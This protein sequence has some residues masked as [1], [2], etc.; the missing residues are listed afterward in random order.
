MVKKKKNINQTVTTMLIDGENV[1]CAVDEEP[2]FEELRMK[3][4][5]IN[6]IEGITGYILR[7]TSDAVI[8]LKDQAML[9]DYAILSSQA[10]DFGQEI[11]ELF[12]LG[13]VENIVV[14]GKDVKVVCVNINENKVSIFME[15]TTDHTNVLKQIST[16]PH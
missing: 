16:S 14:E 9:V 8:D 15:K 3:L 1:I 2:I 7:D 10:Y 12:N 5:A 6:K 4:A 11:S 13:N